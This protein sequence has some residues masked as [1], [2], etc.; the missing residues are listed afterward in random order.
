MG[1]LYQTDGLSVALYDACEAETPGS[2]IDGDVDFF[3][4]QARKT[5]GP[6]LELGAGT[7]RVALRLAEAGFRVTGLELSPH[8]L[9]AARAKL[10]PELGRR[11]DFVRGDMSRFR[12]KR[13]FRLAVIAFRSF[14]H[15]LTPEKQRSC[16]LSIRR[17][18]MKDGRL[19]V[20]LFD[21]RLEFCVPVP[22]KKK[23]WSQKVRHSR[24]GDRV[25]ITAE[26]RVN[27]P[28]TQTF[29]ETWVYTVLGKNRR[30]KRRR[31]ETLSLRWTYRYEMRH[32]LELCGFRPLA[33]YG[34]F[35]GGRPRY[36]AEQVWVA[37]PAR[38]GKR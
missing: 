11:V 26:D 22:A 36:G 10:T 16:L 23:L 27:D 2:V 19:V 12:L 32:L 28:L 20:D 13:K 38:G 4:R 25:V 5:G 35:K 37:A 6:V 18:L 15:L 7:G 14:Q 8:M 31:R 33:C 1:E 30:V 24:T 17:H 34:D 21:P 9:K 29:R 3:I